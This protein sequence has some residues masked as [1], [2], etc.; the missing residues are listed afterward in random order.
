MLSVLQSN[1]VGE[2]ALLQTACLQ[3]TITRLDPR[4]LES[5]SLYIEDVQIDLPDAEEDCSANQRWPSAAGLS[6]LG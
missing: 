3:L 4:E 1:E 2:A 6:I 5:R